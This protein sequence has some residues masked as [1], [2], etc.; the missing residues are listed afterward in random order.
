ML[1]VAVEEEHLVKTAP[2]TEITEI[3]PDET[4]SVNVLSSDS[5][6]ADDILRSKL[7]TDESLTLPALLQSLPPKLPP[8][9]GT[10]TTLKSPNFPQIIPPAFSPVV[11]LK[12][13]TPFE[14][15]EKPMFRA[16]RLSA[17]PP[18]LDSNARKSPSP[19]HNAPP[20]RQ[21]K[22]DEKKHANSMSQSYHPFS[23]Y[24][25]DSWERPQ[26][27]RVPGC[28][29]FSDGALLENRGMNGYQPSKNGDI[30]QQRPPTLYYDYYTGQ[31]I[32]GP[33]FQTHGRYATTGRYR[34]RSRKH[35]HNHR[36]VG[37]Y[38]TYDHAR[39]ASLM[40]GHTPEQAYPVMEQEF[41]GDIQLQ[42]P[43]MHP[44][45]VHTR[46]SIMPLSP[47]VQQIYQPMVESMHPAYSAKK[48]LVSSGTDDTPMQVVET[49]GRTPRRPSKIRPINVAPVNTAYL[50]SVPP[51]FVPQ[52]MVYRHVSQPPSQTLAP[53]RQVQE[54][55]PLRYTSDVVR[56]I[57][58]QA[59]KIG[60]KG[61]RD[62]ALSPRDHY[63]EVISNGVPKPTAREI[64]E[65]PK[66]RL[67]GGDERKISVKDL[68][69][70]FSVQSDDDVFVRNSRND[71]NNKGGSRNGNYAEDGTYPFRR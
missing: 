24:S 14:R 59:F 31:Y 52:T 67:N 26:F 66:G 46:P 7:S 21:E 29:P 25:W 42:Q 64:P 69:K 62:G 22:P 58:R 71:V 70:K 34:R 57:N 19:P 16:R 8:E 5:F 48:Q 32:P 68:V 3:T 50:E 38:S 43:L 60:Q 56:S 33:D 27:Q 4:P 37:N 36:S 6:R 23:T 61:S 55:Q 47:R 15:A 39:S 41:R 40:S 54:E 18:R 13:I 44:H 53:I 30:G 63:L 28:L 10:P 9:K 35:H 12:H 49:I 2:K 17:P 20:E 45:F 1:Q 51:I 11:S 65:Y